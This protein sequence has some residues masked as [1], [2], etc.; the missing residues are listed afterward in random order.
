METSTDSGMWVAS[1]STE[2]VVRRG[3]DQVSGAASPMR[4][5]RARRR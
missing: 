1:A 3:H 4:M 2:I 5:D